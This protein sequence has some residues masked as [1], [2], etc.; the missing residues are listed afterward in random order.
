MPLKTRTSGLVPATPVMSPF[1]VWT[2]S[3]TAAERGNIAART[4]IAGVVIMTTTI[5]DA[6]GFAQEDV[7]SVLSAIPETV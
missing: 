6:P 5:L 1:S 7:L 4:A 3:K 2:G